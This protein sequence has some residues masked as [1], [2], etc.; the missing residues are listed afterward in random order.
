MHL[1]IFIV[2][3]VCGSV[4]AATRGDM[5][6]VEVIGKVLLFIFLFLVFGTILTNPVLL[7]TFGLVALLI[8]IGNRIN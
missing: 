7:V 4:D 1:L 2:W 6:G 3:F 5:S 8:L